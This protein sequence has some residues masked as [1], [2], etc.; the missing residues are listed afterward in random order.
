MSVDTP[1]YTYLS[2]LIGLHIE[3]VD[4]VTIARRKMCYSH[5][6]RL[7]HHE[8]VIG[9]SIRVPNGNQGETLEILVQFQQVAG[10]VSGNGEDNP[11]IAL[12]EDMPVVG[13]I[14]PTRV[15]WA[16]HSLP[17]DCGIGV[18]H[19][20]A[21]HQKLSIGLGGESQLWSSIINGE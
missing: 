21:S 18:I 14:F 5:A 9:G 10:T 3:T 8:H 6:I 11:V 19:I 16:G 4:C 1:A 7:S 13:D 2:N 17:R 20:Q 15:G 12:G